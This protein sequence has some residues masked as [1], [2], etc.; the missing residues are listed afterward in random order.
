MGWQEVGDVAL[1]ATATAVTTFGLVYAFAAPWYRSPLG[2][3]IFAVLASMGLGMGYFTWAVINRPVPVGFYPMRALIFIV[4]FTAVAAAV[5]F[6]L[7]AQWRGKPKEG[8]GN[9]LEN[10]R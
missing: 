1:I 5:I 10:A 8:K 9:D 2:R 7:K 3:S 6:L 4:I